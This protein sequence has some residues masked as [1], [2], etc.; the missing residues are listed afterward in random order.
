MQKKNKYSYFWSHRIR[1]VK[2]RDNY[3]CQCCGYKAVRREAGDLDI[4]H[5]NAEQKTNNNDWNLITL[6]KKCH[7]TKE[8]EWWREA[9]LEWQKNLLEK[10][11]GTRD[12]FSN[13]MKG[14]R[15]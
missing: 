12:I 14:K 2:K 9:M 8:Y 10:Y 15:D 7:L 6:C 3:T 11:Y 5:I 1:T 4:H 13:S